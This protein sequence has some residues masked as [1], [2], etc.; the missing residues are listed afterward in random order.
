MNDVY[1]IDQVIGGLVVAQVLPLVVGYVT[2]RTAG[3]VQTWLLLGL[4][5]LVTVVNEAVNIGSFEPKEAAIRFFSLFGAAVI[6]YKGWQKET[7]AP[8]VQSKGAHLG[9]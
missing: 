1:F 2:E 9:R 6:S 3:K 4:T 7:I 5:A 8:A